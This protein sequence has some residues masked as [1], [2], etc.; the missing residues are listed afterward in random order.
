VFISFLIFSS[1]EQ[2]IFKIAPS[3]QT[4]VALR[5]TKT[6]FSKYRTY[7]QIKNDPQGPWSGNTKILISIIQK[8]TAKRFYVFVQPHTF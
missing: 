8:S 5:V 6:R 2:S 4:I 3:G 1:L 7:G